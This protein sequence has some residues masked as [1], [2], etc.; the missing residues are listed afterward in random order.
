[1]R[2]QLPERTEDT[3][4]RTFSGK[5]FWPL[6]PRPNEVCLID[7]AHAL[8]NICRWTGHTRQFYSVAEHCVLMSHWLESMGEDPRPALLHDASEAYL[9]DIARPVKHLIPHYKQYENNLL[10]S[11]FTHFNIPYPLPD[12]VR[13]LDGVFLL[14]EGEHLITKYQDDP[15]AHVEAYSTFLKQM[16]ESSVILVHFIE[17][18][19]PWEAYIKYRERANE[20]G[21]SD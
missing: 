5:Q 8:A 21:I 7:I 18:W 20:L 10:F 14:Y 6:N 13:L 19:E 17:C 9:S 4:I 16:K 2:I 12:I 1:M 15:Y 3:Y 11:I